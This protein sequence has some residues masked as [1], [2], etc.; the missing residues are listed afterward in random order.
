M[1]FDQLKKAAEIS[2]GQQPIFLLRMNFSKQKHVVDQIV[3]VYHFL[4][5]LLPHLTFHR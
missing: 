4:G 3:I 1:L 5:D 2:E